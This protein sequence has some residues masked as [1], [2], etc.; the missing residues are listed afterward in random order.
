MKFDVS[1]GLPFKDNEMDLINANLSLHY[2]MMDKTI[3]IFDDIY[4]VLKPGGLFI[5]RM[6]SDKN[7]R[8]NAISPGAIRTDI[9]NVPGLSEEES[10]KH[11]EGIASTI[12]CKR[13]GEAEDIANIALFLVSDEANYI[14]GSI[15]AVDGGMGAL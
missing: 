10:K 3:E 8:V 5:G 9:W 6:N 1:K 14:T 4:R 12:P 13:F 15:Y 2:F 11:E 7:V